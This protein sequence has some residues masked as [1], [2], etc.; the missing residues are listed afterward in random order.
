M[1]AVTLLRR[2]HSAT[3]AA[4]PPGYFLNNTSAAGSGDLNPACRNT[5]PSPISIRRM[6]LKPLS[7]RSANICASGRH[8]SPDVCRRMRCRKSLSPVPAR[9]R[10]RIEPCVGARRD[11]HFWLSTLTN[12]VGAAGRRHSRP[13]ARTRCKD[14]NSRQGIQNRTSVPEARGAEPAPCRR[15]AWWSVSRSWISE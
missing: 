13:S 1:V 9:P 11:F 7:K 5:V 15:K 8:P 10:R 2:R 6:P 3:N 14:R 12:D 4:G